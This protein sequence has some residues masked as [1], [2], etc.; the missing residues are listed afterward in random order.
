MIVFCRVD[1]AALVYDSSP[2]NS[3][4]GTMQFGSSGQSNEIGASILSH[5][6][7]A[8]VSRRTGPTT[9]LSVQQVGS[10]SSLPKTKKSVELSKRLGTSLTLLGIVYVQTGRRVE[11]EAVLKELKQRYTG[12]KANGYDIARIYAA[13][14]DKDQAFK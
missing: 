1:G 8:E 9:L 11:A 14:G 5:A 2:L 6:T 4:S 7:D 13:M 3:E 12:H 10:T